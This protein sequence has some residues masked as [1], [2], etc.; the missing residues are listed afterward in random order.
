MT[1][2]DFIGKVIEE[3]GKLGLGGWERLVIILGLALLVVLGKVYGGKILGSLKKA[4]G[5]DTTGVETPGG[6][7]PDEWFKTHPQKPEEHV[8]GGYPDQH[9]GGG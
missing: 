4:S 9:G 3:A 8:P 6:G 1:W 2:Q 7:P 5:P